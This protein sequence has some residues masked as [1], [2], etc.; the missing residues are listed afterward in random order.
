MTASPRP[1]AEHALHVVES[2]TSGVVTLDP[3]GRVTAINQQ[4]A[5]IIGLDREAI[6][7]QS[8]V[9]TLLEDPANE[10]LTDTI[11]E[12]SYDASGRYHRQVELYQGERRRVLDL[13]AN[14]LRDG[15]GTVG[16]VVLVIDDVTETALLRASEQRLAEELRVRNEKLTEAYRGLEEKTQTLADTR[17]RVRRFGLA[18]LLLAAVA[19]GGAGW[20]AWTA[21]APPARPR[22]AAGAPGEA[23]GLTLVPRPLRQTVSVSGTIEPGKVVEVTAPF[24]GE[25]LARDFVYGARVEAGRELLRLD[26]GDIERERRKAVA[27]A[28]TA[29]QKLDDLRDWERGNEVQRARRQL[30]QM[31][32]NLERTQQQVQA[33]GDLLKRGIIAR[34][35][36][37]SLLQ[38]Q[39]QIELQVFSSEQDLAATLRKGSP[40]QV[41]IARLESATAEEK[42]AELTQQLGAARILAPVSGV[43]LRPRA[44][45]TA[46]GAE[47]AA[48]RELAVGARVEQGRTLL[49]IGDLSFLA[50]RGQVDEVDVGRVRPGLAVAVRSAGF[51]GRALAGRVEA[52]SSQ[53]TLERG[54]RTPRARFDVLVT[55][56]ELDEAVRERLRI[57]MS[58][59]LEIVLYENPAALLLPPDRI[60]RGPNG[61]VARVRPGG[62]GDPREVPLTL[63]VSLPEGIEVTAGLAPGDV[64]LAH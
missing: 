1:G 21:D 16:G 63:G 18:G 6:T 43:A 4:A 53:A 9:A 38:Q 54:G 48:S 10:H 50:V 57:G 17:R 46:A 8:L 11:V 20:Y 58:A 24:A 33:A 35:E 51:G 14:L 2:M 30:A 42:L 34:Q 45:A 25:I 36:H 44:P 28:M 5:R 62:Q 40:D 26:G 13:R 47:A 60:R 31:R 29:R 49:E 22:P 3:E 15:Q 41:T 19:A 59:A 32:Q 56:R 64:V 27:A 7:G 55:I 61:P 12:A 52:V 23:P 39:R 37:D